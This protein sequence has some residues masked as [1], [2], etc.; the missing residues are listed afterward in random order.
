M[1]DL[2]RRP[3]GAMVQELMDATGWQPHTVRGVIS[4]ALK[5]KLRIESKREGEVTRYQI[6]GAADD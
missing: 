4:G 6:V 5:R 2:L 3:S 1:I